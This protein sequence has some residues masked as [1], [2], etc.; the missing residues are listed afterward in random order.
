M[1]LG[2]FLG[3]KEPSQIFFGH[4]HNPWGS[5]AADVMSSSLPILYLYSLGQLT[6]GICIY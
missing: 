1:Q 3:Q 5:N 4:Y 2:F 6:S